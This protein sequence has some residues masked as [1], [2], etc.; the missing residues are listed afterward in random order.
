MWTIF[1]VSFISSILFTKPL[2]YF[3]EKNKI[4]DI[5]NHR[6]VHKNNILRM[7]G[8]LFL[9]GYLSSIAYLYISSPDLFTTQTKG[10]II[11]AICIAILGAV[12]DL[13]NLNS[14]LKFIIECL[15][16][17]MVCQF[18]IS[19]DSFALFGHNIETN[20]WA[21]PIT[22]FWIVGIT[23]ALNLLD[24]LDG[25]AGGVA[26][27]IMITLIYLNQ[28]GFH[29]A[30]LLPAILGGLLVFLRL[31][32][33][34][35]KIFM[36]DV[37]S[38]F[39]GFHISVFSLTMLSFKTATLGILTP[40]LLIGL[41]VIDTSLAIIRRANKGQKIFEADKSHIHHRL[42][43]M[44]VSHKNVVR[45]LH[46]VSIL[47]SILVIYSSKSIQNTSGFLIFGSGII[48]TICIY[49]FYATQKVYANGK[50]AGHKAGLRKALYLYL[51]SQNI[52]NVDVPYEEKLKN[53]KIE[54]IESIL[55]QAY[56]EK[57]LNNTA[58]FL[59]LLEVQ[60]T[61]KEIEW[62]DSPLD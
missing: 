4:Y 13:K 45:V 6:S 10:I 34:P 43:S 33:N 28:D 12:D 2:F 50:I 56:Y 30:I 49:S 61:E 58:K 44:G 18:D 48:L 8:L 35:A 20:Q 26:A 24:G 23:N 41:P 21:T 52:K 46:S 38:L 39:L 59:E 55:L 32:M 5:P 9:F 51:Y 36:G 37:G 60:D 29:T 15:I 1:F 16:A 22:I 7:G 11:G 57:G 54:D 31:N 40:V 19:I 14:K 17:Y 42:L 47:L 53:I 25:L 62:D 3:L 27:I